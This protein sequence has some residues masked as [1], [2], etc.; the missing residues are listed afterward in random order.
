MQEDAGF[1]FMTGT[2][3]WADPH[4]FS[5]IILFLL[6]GLT[7]VVQAQELTGR[8]MGWDFSPAEAAGPD[9]LNQLGHRCRRG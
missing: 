7:P 4:G 5:R 9:L 2:N 3:A 8:Y 6:H 1:R